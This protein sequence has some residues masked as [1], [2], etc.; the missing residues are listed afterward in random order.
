M[1]ETVILIAIFWLSSNVFIVGL[2]ACH[3]A[4][5]H[6]AGSTLQTIQTANMNQEQFG[7]L[8]MFLSK[9][10]G[11]P[12]GFT[13]FGLITVTKEL[14]LTLFGLYITYGVVLLQLEH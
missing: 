6:S 1:D 7:Q 10:N 5:M 14:I 4:S 13:I 3:M 2:I 9:L 11:P 12:M 8:Q